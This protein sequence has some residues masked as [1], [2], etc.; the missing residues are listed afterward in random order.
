MIAL[1]CLLPIMLPPLA[2]LAGDW[3]FGP[4]AALWGF[5]GGFVLGLA[6]AAATVWLFTR[7]KSD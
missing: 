2:A 1:G 5:V 6:A 7:L 3:L 4:S